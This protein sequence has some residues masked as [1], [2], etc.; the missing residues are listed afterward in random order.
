MVTNVSL[1]DIDECLTNAH[2]CDD[3]QRAIC[4][5]NNGSF[6]CQ[7]K[8][9][10]TGSGFKNDCGIIIII[11]SCILSLILMLIPINVEC[12]NGSIRLMNRSEF[13]PGQMQ[14]RVEVCNGNTYFTVC[15]D[16]WDALEARVVCH[17]LGHNTSSMFSKT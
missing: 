14:G 4:T 1:L 5:N 6:S 8:P 13:V 17:Y 10:Y 11:R 12:N 15:N 9:G 2:S 7:C 3:P 16:F